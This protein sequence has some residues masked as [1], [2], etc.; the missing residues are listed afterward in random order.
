MSGYSTPQGEIEVDTVRCPDLYF[1]QMLVLGRRE[2]AGRPLMQAALP[3]FQAA[4]LLNGFGKNWS[5]AGSCKPR[6]PSLT[7]LYCGQSCISGQGLQAL[8]RDLCWGYR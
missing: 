2:G 7:S 4:V 6:E 3:G 5:L 1:V 8:V